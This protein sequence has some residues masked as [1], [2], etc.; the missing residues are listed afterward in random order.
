MLRLYRFLKKPW[1]SPNSNVCCNLQH[2]VSY[3]YCI[4]FYSV[5]HTF[6]FVRVREVI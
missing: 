5:V 2:F 6:L 4:D 1:E 3:K